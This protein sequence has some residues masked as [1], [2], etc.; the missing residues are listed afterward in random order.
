MLWSCRNILLSVKPSDSSVF[1]RTFVFNSHSQMVMECQPIAAS[2]CCT[3][4]SRSWFLCIFAT[5]NSRF[6]FGILQH[7]EL[8][9]LNFQLVAL[10]P[11]VHARST[12]SRRYISCTSASRCQDCPT[13]VDSSACSGIHAPTTND[14]PPFPVS[15]FDVNGCHICMASLRRMNICHNC[16][17]ITLQFIKSSQK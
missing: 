5:Q 12:R 16:Y 2:S 8:S 4:K 17:Y 13:V 10:P 9:T 11:R 3:F 6:V 14:A 1:S 7:S 15:I